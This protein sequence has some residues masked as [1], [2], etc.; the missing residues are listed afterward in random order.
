MAVDLFLKIKEIKGESKDD[1]HGGEIEIESYSWGALNSGSQGAGGGGGSGK[2]S[3]QDFNIMKYVDSSSPELFFA[4]VSGK[5]FPT[6][7]FVAR[8]AGEKPLEYLKIKLSD[9]LIS[10]VQHG[11]AA[12]GDRLTESVSINYAKI[13]VEYTPQD[14]KGAG[15]GAVKS[16]WDVKANKKI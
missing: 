15:G 1:K 6:A 14:S 8:K 13:E 5:H 9:V 4:C 10:S 3:V 2:V 16:G 12:G 7:E 11:G